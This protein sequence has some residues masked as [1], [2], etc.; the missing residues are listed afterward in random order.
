MSIKNVTA[1]EIKK[2]PRKFYL[3]LLVLGSL[4]YVINLYITYF[5]NSLDVTSSLYSIT[6]QFPRDSI[7][8]INL[9]F[10]IWII[11]GIG[12]EFDN[13]IIQRS[14]SYGASI[15]DFFIGKIIYILLIAIYFVTLSLIGFFITANYHSIS[16]NNTFALG[17]LAHLFIYLI[18]YGLFCFLVIVIIRKSISALVIFFVYSFV[19]IT[20]GLFMFRKYSIDVSFL[21]MHILKNFNSRHDDGIILFFL[22]H[23]YYNLFLFLLLLMCLFFAS[24]LILKRRDLDPL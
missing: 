6:D 14:I 1:L 5:V 12:Y 7:K 2:L 11:L 13:K 20:F 4:Y 15:N 10:P 16:F 17:F 8:A 9:L 19:E 23:D 22:S 18:A 21:P 3:L 24:L